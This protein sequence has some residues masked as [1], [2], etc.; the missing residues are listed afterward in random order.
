MWI[1]DPDEE[2]FRAA[3]RDRVPIVAVTDRE[4]LPYVLETD[5]VPVRAGQG[6]P[7]DEIAVVLARRLDDRGPSLAAALP[8]LREAVVDD[9]IRSAARR[10]ALLAAGFVVPGVEMR[11]LTLSQ[12]RLVMRIALAYGREIDRSRATEVLG[13]VGAG[14]GFRAVARESLGLLPVAGWALRGAIA[15]GGTTAVGEAA[16][17]FF[18][19]RS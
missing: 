17:R 4:R 8:V 13:V 6:F 10:N 1:G 2:A 9:L 18:A 16:R 3:A 12:V 19:E 11:V 15:F 14:F 5:I 7:V